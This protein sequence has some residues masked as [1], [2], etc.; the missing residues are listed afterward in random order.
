MAFRLRFDQFVR[1]PDQTG[2][3]IAPGLL[4]REAAKEAAQPASVPDGLQLLAGYVWRILVVCA[5]LYLLWVVMG[6]LT[7]VLIPLFLAL[8]LTAALWPVK[9]WLQ[10]RGM[11]RGLAVT[12]TLLLLVAN[13]FA[14]DLGT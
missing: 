7:E 8:L 14:H 10:R 1:E 6:Q 2:P 5:G 11:P 3:S 13:C 4:A 9:T 12:A